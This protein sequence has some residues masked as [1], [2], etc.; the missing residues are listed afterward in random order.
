MQAII[1]AAGMGKRL[2]QLT[3]S[4]TKCMIEVNGVKL[5]DRMILSLL[6]N[7]ISNIIIV[8]GYQS[9]NLKE[10]V[11]NKWN[12]IDFVFI[13]NKD[14]DKTNNIYSLYL[15]KDYLG[16]ED[17]ILLESDLIF[18]ESL[19]SKLINDKRKDLAVVSK[20]K[21]WMDGTVV[22]LEND[23][24]KS[25][26]LKKDQILIDI[27]SFYKTVNIYKF[28]KEFS[29]NIY[30]PI[31][32]AYCN[33][34]NLS[35]YYEEALSITSTINPSILG[36]VDVKDILWYEIDNM[37]DYRNASTIF[38]NEDNLHDS[39]VSRYGGYWRFP[40]LID[41]CYL[42]NPYFPTKKMLSQIASKSD[43][44][45]SNYPSSL[46][47]INELVSDIFD[48][49]S[50]YLTIGNGASE[51]ISIMIDKIDGS[52]VAVFYPSFD[53][54]KN[55]LMRGSCIITELNSFGKNSE[56]I[57]KEI[58]DASI[59]HDY[60][61]FVNP[62]NPTG[63]FIDV[64]AIK[65]ILPALKENKCTLILDESFVDFSGFGKTSSMIS[66]DILENNSN[67]V[68]I[69]S[70]SK[71]F[72]V[73]GLRL[74][75]IASSN[76]DVIDYIKSSESIWNINSYAENFLELLINNMDDYWNSCF[77]LAQER[78]RFALNLEN[79]GIIVYSSMANFLLI[80]IPNNLKSIQFEDYLLKNNILLKSLKNKKGIESDRF[81]RIAVKDE[82][83]N[84]Y[85]CKIVKEFMMI[86]KEK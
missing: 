46:K 38:N 33:S 78:S 81:F 45:L 53:E 76:T 56:E 79:I 57:K 58:Y 86:E 14:F 61:F 66:N 39:Y 42:V 5:I 29:K 47:I 60:I 51:L 2:G 69:K 85:F 30:V 68:V 28:S 55:R 20:Y 49:N 26:I 80:E 50:K 15:A 32:E 77:I 35:N 59:E 54:Y 10:Y 41:Y 12:S 72:G 8:T 7:N 9:N 31:L 3:E 24:I 1:L 36:A 4:N 21:D 43:V 22:E 18:E 70:I 83:S 65:S 62:E 71:S 37:N 13:E 82:K 17:T 23:R 74:G 73:P 64:E 40:D 75:L 67:L 19:I 63:N 84:N 34:E 11:S 25:F 16:S 44:L 6:N 48:V 27:F 52:K